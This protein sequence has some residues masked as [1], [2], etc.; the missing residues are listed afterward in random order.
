MRAEASEGRKSTLMTPVW[1]WDETIQRGTDYASVERVREYDERMGAMRNVAAEAEKIVRLLAFSPG[2]T[3]VE[4]GTG[5]GAFAREAARRC[6]RV[7][8]LDVSPVMLEYA[9]QRAG[10]EGLDNLEFHEA[11]FLTYEHQGEPVAAIVSQLA[12]HHLPDAWKLIGLERLAGILRPGGTFY[13]TD[14]VFPD[15]AQS[16]WP[17]Y[18]Q[19][20]VES[21][22]ASSRSEMAHHIRQEFS[23]FDWMMRALLTHAG[24]VV[25]EAELE[26]EFLGHYLCR[27]P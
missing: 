19:R 1:Q 4:V 24:F 17:A 26:R 11:G 9:A 16:E 27:K 2:D 18:F 10:E 14:V 22:P 13:L 15:G 12:L 7:I 25:E 8:A 23:V 21:M 6:R 3:L 5:T 20:L